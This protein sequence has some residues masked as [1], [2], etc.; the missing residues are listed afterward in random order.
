MIGAPAPPLFWAKLQRDPSGREVLHWHPLPDHCADVAACCEAL[1]MQPVIRRRLAR[2][3]GLDDLAGGQIERLSVLAALHDAGKFNV[4]FQNKALLHPEFTS[5]HVAPILGLFDPN[6]WDEKTER[7]SVA[8]CFDELARW[9]VDEASFAH[10]FFASLAHHGKPVRPYQKDGRTRRCWESSHGL[11]PFAG[12]ANLVSRTRRWFPRAYST[13]GELLPDAP[14]FQHAFSGLVTLADWLGSDTD[15]FPYST[16]PSADRM[17][18]ARE[19]AHRALTRVGL[20]PTEARRAPNGNAAGFE[21]I[22]GFPPREMQ[23]QVI[24]LPIAD[25]PS[26]TILESETGS[27]KTEAALGRFL[28]LFHA[29]QVDGLYFAL[30]TRTAATQMH[31][32]VVNAVE[33]AFPPGRRPPVVLAVPGYLVVDRLEG[34]R[35]PDFEVL[36]PD[37]GF[38]ACAGIDRNYLDGVGTRTGLPR[39]RGDR[40]AP[41]SPPLTA[42]KPEVQ[43]FVPAE[44]EEG[45]AL[46]PDPEPEP[47]ASSRLRSLLAPPVQDL[48]DRDPSPLPDQVARSLLTFVARVAFD[49]NGKIELRSHRRP[50]REELDRPLLHPLRLPKYTR[51]AGQ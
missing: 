27:G 4:G 47:S 7:L 5:G 1:L 10:L 37:D 33:R 20:D 40:P 26:L 51:C 50:P 42:D 13:A 2:L 46:D 8:L 24:R 3:G 38:P 14:A 32:R 44:S 49:S 34:T 43:R 16:D 11:D 35:L 36:W 15:F 22:F 18:F 41:W 6:F 12:I 45:A 29:G 19:A 48:D 30:P 39:V 9:C 21:R 17:T 25:A 28:E 31:R 23:Q